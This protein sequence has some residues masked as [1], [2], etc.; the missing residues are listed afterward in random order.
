ML[1]SLKPRISISSEEHAAIPEHVALTVCH[2]SLSQDLFASLL[3]KELAE[4]D[5]LLALAGQRPSPTCLLSLTPLLLLPCFAIQLPMTLP[6]ALESISTSFG[7]FSRTP[8]CRSGREELPHV[9]GKR[10]PSKAVGTERGHQ[11]ADR[12]RPQSHTTSQSDHMD[13]SLV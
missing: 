11:R 2:S 9:Q 1:F 13:H 3:C 8:S 6:P 10:N 7:N 5:L 4:R 12:L